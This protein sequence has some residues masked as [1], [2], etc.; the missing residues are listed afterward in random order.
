MKN[1]VI[2]ANPQYMETSVMVSDTNNTDH[3]TN[4]A[5]SVTVTKKNNY[6]ENGQN[7]K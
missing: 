1:V 2:Y 6:Y 5:D 7:S 4:Y 3:E